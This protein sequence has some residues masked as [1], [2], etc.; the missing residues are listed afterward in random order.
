M[1]FLRRTP[2]A[3][4]CVI[5][6]M[7]VAFLGSLSPWFMW[8]IFNTYVLLVAVLLCMGF[9]VRT[10]VFSLRKRWVLPALFLL[11]ALV[12]NVSIK[13]FLVRAFVFCL[14]Q[15]GIYVV[16]FNLP[17]TMKGRVVRFTACCMAVICMV[18]LVAYA[19]FL[20]AGMSMSPTYTM[21]EGVQKTEYLNYR[22]FLL[23]IR[24][25]AEEAIPRFH[26]VFLEPG[27][28]AVA[29]SMLLYAQAYDMKKWYNKALLVTIVCTLSLAG[30]LLTAMSFFIK[31]VLYERQKSKVAIWAVLLLVAG[32]LA[33]NIGL[34]YNG[35][36]NLFN[37]KIIQR[38]QVD[39]SGNLS[40]D[41][42]TGDEFEVAYNNLLRSDHVWFGSDFDASMFEGGNAGYR[43]YIY[44]FGLV[45]LGLIILVYLSCALSYP[46]RVALPLLMLYAM[47]FWN[48]GTPLWFNLIIPYI[49][50]FPV[51][52]DLLVKK[53]T[54]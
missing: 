14:I 52:R 36:N 8:P 12:Y 45:G 54:V 11:V 41:N 38:L 47:I 28:I 13:G 46:R 20:F 48:G 33:W 21:L 3:E 44:N 9:V 35:G 4:W 6:A 2:V 43:V 19:L 34:E 22:F 7:F 5:V 30:Y 1:L 15:W 49:C 32:F 53:E 27:H 24:A 25:F 18:S 17:D 39:D 51:Y 37:E 23:N 16:L 26:A 31:K 10:R 42:R 40:G 50:A 29:A